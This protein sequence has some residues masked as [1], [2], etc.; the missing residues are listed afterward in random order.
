MYSTETWSRV[1]RCSLSSV[2]YLGL[3]S[4][5]RFVCVCGS[6]CVQSTV[7]SLARLIH[8]LI[9]LHSGKDYKITGTAI[10]YCNDHSACN[11]SSFN[12]RANQTHLCMEIITYTAIFFFHKSQSFSFLHSYFSA[13]APSCFLFKSV[14]HD[15]FTVC[16]PYVN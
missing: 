12:W 2:F 5:A 14:A 1:Q 11:L 10:S 7:T 6:M 9:F 15:T 4:G 13:N 16:R 8:F 3:N